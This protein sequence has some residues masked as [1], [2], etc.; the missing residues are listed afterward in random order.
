[1]PPAATSKGESANVDRQK[2]NADF[3][4]QLL[5]SNRIAETDARDPN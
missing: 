2:K 5:A 4:D 3:E 1:M